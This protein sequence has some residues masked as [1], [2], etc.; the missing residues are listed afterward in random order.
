MA[1]IHTPSKNP[2]TAVP[3][4]P[5]NA[6]ET[7]RRR[8]WVPGRRE[9]ALFLVAVGAIALHIL[10]DSFFQPN[11]GTSAGD[12]LVGGLVPVAVLG[13]AAYLYGRTRAGVRA[14]MAVSIGI[15][16]VA[17]SAE[18]MHYGG[19]VGLSGDDY[20]G[21][22]GIPAGL[23]L[24]GIGAW[25]L[26]RSR[27]LDSLPRRYGR[28]LLIGFAA[29]LSIPLFF[30]P[31]VF[32]Y[33]TTHIGRAVVPEANL[34]AAY[35]DVKFE[36]SDGLELEGWYIPSKNGAA[37]ISP[38]RKG[39]QTPARVL[40][41][42]GYGVLLFDRRG[43]GRSD[44]DPNAFGW[45]GVKDIQAAV[46][47]LENRPDV[48]PDRIGG[49]GLSVAGEVMLQAAAETDDLDAVVSEGAGY[50]S[51]KEGLDGGGSA[52]EKVIGVPFFATQTAAVAV[53]S[54]TSVPPK[55]TDLMPRVAEPVFVIYSPKGQGGERELSP[56][57]YE[58]ANEPKQ[59]WAAPKG[60]HTGAHDGQPAEYERRVVGFFDRSLRGR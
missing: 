37:V 48:E 41:R 36:T 29:L 5:A 32:S 52:V 35:E 33:G 16:G 15:F 11:P 50:R 49:L 19:E 25:T 2:S 10:D 26:W 12:H 46:D 1:L 22:L 58:A 8:S 18:A 45:E 7:H 43:E 55:L 24:L 6:G 4:E 23:L 3:E 53:F 57:Y 14:V 30:Y 40:A 38:G 44:G 20:T 31:L 9:Y 13:L 51:I 21:L 27:K 60:G 17:T 56:K 42:H 54:N 59:V 47:F 39:S 28:R 34:G